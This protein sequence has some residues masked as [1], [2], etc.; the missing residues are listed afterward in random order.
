MEVL[1]DGVGVAVV[2]VDPKKDYGWKSG[3]IY[4]LKDF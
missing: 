4:R 3:T 1:G 2:P